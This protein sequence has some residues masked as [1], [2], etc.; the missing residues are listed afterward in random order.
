MGQ[1]Y[2]LVQHSGA[3][4]VE[5][6]FC[7]E[8]A[9]KV[10]IAGKH[11]IQVAVEQQVASINSKPH[12]QWACVFGREYPLLI[13]P[14]VRLLTMATQSADVER[15]C[16]VHKLVHTKMR[17]RL[18]NDNVRKLVYCYVNLRLI[19]SM[20]GVQ[21]DDDFVDFLAGAFDVVE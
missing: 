9:D 11:H 16:K 6:Q 19:K 4:G 1:L 21:L 10:A 18:K 7:R 3:F 14:A 12:L 17:N 13:E 8:A 15:C 20:Q 5:V 2:Q